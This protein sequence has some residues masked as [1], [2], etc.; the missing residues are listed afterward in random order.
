LFVLIVEPSEEGGDVEYLALI[1][2]DQ[3]VW[4]ELSDG[5]RASV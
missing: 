4:D 5:E 2:S 3:T 1:H